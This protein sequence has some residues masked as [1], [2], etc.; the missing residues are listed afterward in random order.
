MYDPIYINNAIQ[1]STIMKR[2]YLVFLDDTKYHKWQ[3]RNQLNCQKEL[4][5]RLKS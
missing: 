2:K 1:V 4:R 5:K 3:W